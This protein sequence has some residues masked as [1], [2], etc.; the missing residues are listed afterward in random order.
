MV[1]SMEKMTKRTM[2][3]AIVRAAETGVWDVETA[4][5]VTFAEKEIAALDKKAAKAKERAA[6]KKAEGDALKDAVAAALT[7]DFAVI[8][9]IAAKVDIE[10]ATVAKVTYRLTTLVRDGVAKKEEVTVETAE[11]K[12]RKVMAYALA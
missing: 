3:E 9:D 12:K 6:A 5:V 10:D 8:A 1:L 11:G 4:E 2:F 7:E